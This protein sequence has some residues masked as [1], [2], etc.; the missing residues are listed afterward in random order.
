[1]AH[2]KKN[3]LNKVVFPMVDAS[4]ATVHSALAASDITRTIWA[5]NQGT[6]T[7]PSLI[8]GPS[9][10]ATVVRSG[11][12]AQV[13]K[14]AECNYDALILRATAS[15]D[16][17]QILF[18]QLHD[19]DDSD[20]LSALTVIQS[21]ASDASSHAQQVNS[22]VLVMSDILSKVYAG[23][24]DTQS[25]LR[26][27]ITTTGVGLNASALSDLASAVWANA[28]GS[29]VNSK[30][31]K[32]A[33]R[34]TKAVATNS[35]VSDLTSDLR[36]FLVVM[37]G[38][39]SDIYSALSDLQS[40]FQ[41]R[42]PKAVATNSQ[43]S[44]L[45]SD[46][47]SD[48]RS[49]VVTA[50]VGLNA[51]ALSDIGS[52]VWA[53][54][55][56]SDVN[57]K[58]GKLTSRITSQ[59][60][61]SS[62]IV[63]KIWADATPV[64]INSRLLVNQSSV[65]NLSAILSD[66][67]SDFQSRVPKLV[68]TNSQVSDLASDVKSA[69]AALTITLSPSDISDIASAVIAGGTLTASKVWADAAASDLTSKVGKLTSR[70][71]KAAATASGLTLAAADMSSAESNIYSMLSDLQ[72]DFQSRVP[73]AVATASGLTIAAADMSSA[74]SNIYSLLSDLQSDFQ[75]RV[76][77]A[78]ATNSQL[79]DLA[80][81]LKSFMAAGVEIG[82]SSISD[83]GSRV[84][85]VLASDMSDILSAAGQANSR[86][87]KLVSDTSDIYSLLSDL[88]SNILSRVPKAV[89]TNSQLSDLAS[90]LKSAITVAQSLASDAH[91]AAEQANSRALKLVS[92]TSDIKS[93]IAAGLDISTSSISDI[94]SRV[95]AVLASDV[96]DILSA[97]RQTN[98]RALKVVSDTSDIYSLLSDLDSNFQS[99]VPKAVATQSYLSDVE[100][101]L[102]SVMVA[103]V[104][105]N[106][107]ALSDIN[108]TILDTANAVD[109]Q[110]VRNALKL[111]VAAA[112]GKIDGADTTTVHVRNLTDTK[113]RVTAIVD[114]NGNRTSVV[115]DLT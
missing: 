2:F 62:D 97:A 9:K 61:S 41:S 37:S 113:N 72:S 99:R 35:Q 23:V 38:I 106:A 25:D 102:R 90:D 80:S 95:Y 7:A 65:S 8:T 30:I 22:R 28:I 36:S 96:S 56:G 79:S 77:K 34:I 6:S 18:L 39:Q 19:F 33:S 31:G 26:S 40:D 82:A 111:T 51:S 52:A 5:W 67:Y 20:L 59:V 105:L 93:A 48:L 16:A 107:S 44:D 29:D 110:T 74:E 49:L 104:G 87:L 86:A 92:D 100:S 98:S 15:G 17:D 46:L 69:V 32:L 75:S 27:L 53:N 91:S 43:L 73:K 42:V 112:A 12:F 21:M 81:D 103:G 11:I 57:S 109:N 4:D 10:A 88:N 63:S 45:I 94:G 58:V 70:I 3:Q 13:L 68:A 14:A 101:N 55:I 85:A 47:G 66:F 60:T 1:M 78:V 64:Q 71:T 54:A 24:S 84:L 50:G 89:A 115:L 76:P 108:S 114:A 83:I